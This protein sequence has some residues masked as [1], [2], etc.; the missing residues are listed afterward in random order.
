MIMPS[1]AAHDSTPFTA[2]AAGLDA[3]Q[4]SAT[5]PRQMIEH[6]RAEELGRSCRMS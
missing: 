4:P 3:H 5:T 1:E 6:L 2:Y